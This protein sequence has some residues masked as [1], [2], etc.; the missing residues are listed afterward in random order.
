MTMHGISDWD[1]AGVVFQFNGVEICWDSGWK[2]HQDDGNERQK[3]DP[4]SFGIDSY[5]AKYM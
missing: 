3:R 4:Q 1:I 2:G 5:F